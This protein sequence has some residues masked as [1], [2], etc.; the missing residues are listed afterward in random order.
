[1][2]FDVAGVDHEPFKI[3]LIDQLLQ[4]LFPDTFIAPAAEAAVGVFPIAIVRRQVAPRRSG[5]QYPENTVEKTPIVL[6]DAAPLALLSRKTSG[7]QFP[8]MIAQVVTVK[9]G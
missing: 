3:R 9:R 4:Q 7:E 2:G 1:M 8:G 5:A 6:G